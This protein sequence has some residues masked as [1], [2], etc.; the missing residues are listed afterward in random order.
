MFSSFY[1]FPLTN[2]PRAMLL[3]GGAPEMPLTRVL[4]PH[5]PSCLHRRPMCLNPSFLPG[6]PANTPS[7]T[8]P[9]AWD[10]PH[11][12]HIPLCLC[13]SLFLLSWDPHIHLAWPS[14]ASS[15]CL[16]S[17]TQKK[18]CI[19]PPEVPADP[20]LRRAHT[21]VPGALR[22]VRVACL[23]ELLGT[24]CACLGS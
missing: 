8:T 22:H 16:S 24:R 3:T 4:C 7:S 11:L 19:L 14:Q 12:G 10:H 23:F 6:R 9:T 21:G 1:S 17:P 15:L 18:T 5:R 13:P 20:P 2:V